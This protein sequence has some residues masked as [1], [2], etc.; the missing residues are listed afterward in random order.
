MS[1]AALLPCLCDPY[2][3]KGWLHLYK[4]VWKNEVDN[5]YVLLQ[6]YLEVPIM[7][8]CE[9][10]VEEA[11]GISFLQMG[12]MMQHG[13]GIR[14]LL[15]NCTEDHVVLL[16]DDAWIIRPGA[17]DE[18]FKIIETGKTDIIGSTR[19]SCSPEIIARCVTVFD[20][21]GEGPEHPI[22]VCP[23]LWPNFL[24][25]KR[26]DLLATDR[27]FNANSWKKGEVLELLGDYVCK[28]DCGSDTFVWASIQL[29]AMK[30]RFMYAHQR[31]CSSDDLKRD[32]LLR[33]EN[34]PWVH[35]GSLSSLM[36]PGSGLLRDSKHVPIGGQSRNVP[37]EH[38]DKYDIPTGREVVRRLSIAS[39]FLE[40]FPL[41]GGKFAYFNQIYNDSL[42]DSLDRFH[43]ND[44]QFDE[45]KKI[46][47]ELL[48][49]LF[50]D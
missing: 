37:N 35:F 18:Q 25:A 42:K 41:E 39:N 29:R 23:N 50:G 22:S 3:L 13:D 43:L 26:D 45:F 48:P 34:L 14:F 28:E 21:S 8:E 32:G 9:R 4:T 36:N 31:H 15:E 38:Y 17:L 27:N 33:V 2:I 24:F 49:Q 30:K 40:S 44:V 11:G 20:L 19:T 16:E 10:L 1:R 5:L 12:S 7:K 46:Y 6:G 47:K